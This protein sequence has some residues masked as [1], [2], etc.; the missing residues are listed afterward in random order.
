M[1]TK[2]DWSDDAYLAQLAARSSDLVAYGYFYTAVAT[3]LGIPLFA[4]FALMLGLGFALLAKGGELG[5]WLFCW[6][7]TL[8]LGLLLFFLFRLGRKGIQGPK[9]RRL[10]KRYAELVANQRRESVEDIAYAVNKDEGTVLAELDDAIRLGFL[11]DYVL[12]R[13]ALR[14]SKTASESASAARKAPQQAVTFTCKA[15]GAT[16][17]CSAPAG[18]AVKC[19]YCGSPWGGAPA[20][21]IVAA[22]SENSRCFDFKRA[23]QSERERE[24]GRLAA[25]IGESKESMLFLKKELAQLPQILTTGEELL[26]IAAGVPQGF[27]GNSLI[28]LTD[29]RLILLYAGLAG[30]KEIAIELDRLRSAFGETGFLAGKIVVEDASTS[31][32]IKNVSGQVIGPFVEKLQDALDARKAEA[33]AT[34]AITGKKRYC[35]T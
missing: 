25:E 30:R 14:V 16:N 8:L 11:R 24:Y 1:S 21:A 20:Q 29:S 2:E 17:T 3:L 12:D 5:M 15:C 28:A 6:G 26:A 4:L 23:S 27:M 7:T 13:Q 32:A 10:F 31:L 35:S 9:R 18:T 33:A 19:E 22:R 34:E